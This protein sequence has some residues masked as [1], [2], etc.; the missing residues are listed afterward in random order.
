[1]SQFAGLKFSSLIVVLLF[2]LPAS[3]QFEVSPD[4]FDPVDKKAPAVAHKA[5]VKRSPAA[6]TG[7]DHRKTSGLTPRT[8]AS[9]YQK[10]KPKRQAAI[11]TW[12]RG[13]D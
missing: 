7:G 8:N 2:A 4:H 3:A 12:P 1:M 6:A 10:A 5:T 11:S 9:A 13:R